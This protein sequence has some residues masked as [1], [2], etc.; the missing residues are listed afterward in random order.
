MEQRLSKRI[1][2]IDQD[3]NTPYYPIDKGSLVLFNEQL[4]KQA[5]YGASIQSKLTEST[6]GLEELEDELKKEVQETGGITLRYAGYNRFIPADSDHKA[7]NYACQG[8]GALA[9]KMYLV[10]VHETLESL[11]IRTNDHYRLQ[12][13]IY[14]ELDFIVHPDYVE[15]ISKVLEE[16][17][18][19]T[20]INL[21][22]KTRYSGEV[23]H[24]SSWDQCH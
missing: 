5:L 6:I 4:I 24:G 10:I 22:L 17:Y 19:Q 3:P 12:A 1:L 9:M 18:P 11:G 7:L 23:L 21:G 2:Y 20:S 8:L 15:T 13:T 14:D 16:S